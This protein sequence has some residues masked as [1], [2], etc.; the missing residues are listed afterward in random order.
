MYHNRLYPM[1][2][3]YA[4]GR[5]RPRYRVRPRSLAVAAVWAYRIAVLAAFGAVAGLTLAAW[6]V[7][8]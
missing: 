3:Y 5:A 6:L 1:G 7:R 2:R 4:R 8:P